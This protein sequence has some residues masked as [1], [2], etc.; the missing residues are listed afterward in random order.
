M[1]L[2][3]GIQATTAIEG[4][5]LS[6]TEV[7]HRIE[8]KKE[9]PPSKEYLGIEV[10]NILRVCNGLTKDIRGVAVKPL[11]VELIRHFNR[12]V[13][14]DLKL[15]KDVVPGPSESIRWG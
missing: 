7:L 11:D 9:L 8:G 15:E 2:A 3:R 14:R 10:D 6:E 5:T 4:N 12:E 1:Y 13:L